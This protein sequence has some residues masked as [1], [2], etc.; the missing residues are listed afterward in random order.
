MINFH[1]NTIISFLESQMII[2]ETISTMPILSF[3]RDDITR[4]RVSNT[5]HTGIPGIH[6]TLSQSTSLIGLDILF[7]SEPHKVKY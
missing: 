7:S 4:Q 2:P 3:L 6:L 1:N 5:F